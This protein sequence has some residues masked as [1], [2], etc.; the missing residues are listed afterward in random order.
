[1]PPEDKANLTPNDGIPGSWG[2]TVSEIK[3]IKGS[4]ANDASTATDKNATPV[5][6]N[7]PGPQP[8]GGQH[9]VTFNSH[10]VATTPLAENQHPGSSPIKVMAT[11]APTAE[12]LTGGAQI[13][14]MWG[15]DATNEWQFMLD[16]GYLVFSY[17]GGGQVSSVKTVAPAGLT[18]NEFVTVEADV[19]PSTGKVSFWKTP[20]GGTR[21]QLGDILSTTPRKIQ[22]LPAARVR[23]GQDS[24][25]DNEFHGSISAASVTIDEKRVLN[26]AATASGITDDTGAV[27]SEYGTTVNQ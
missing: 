17:A 23:M 14:G 6:P 18:A 13:I 20:V 5:P 2:V 19:D 10:G 4:I 3:I 11:L 21:V 24:T 12:D 1:M 25:G 16:G 9:A 7:I 8:P 15:N 27:W 22:A 26:P